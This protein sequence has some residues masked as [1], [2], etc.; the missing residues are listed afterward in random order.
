MDGKGSEIEITSRISSLGS[1]A[2]VCLGEGIILIRKVLK[3]DN[4][5]KDLHVAREH[6]RVC[7]SSGY[8]RSKAGALTSL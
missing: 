4:A 1:Q 2:Y 7:S 3:N 6:I 8:S 5:P